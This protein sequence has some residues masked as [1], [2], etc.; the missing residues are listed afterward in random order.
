VEAELEGTGTG[1]SI[2]AIPDVPHVDPVA[3]PPDWT[4]EG[5]GPHLS[6]D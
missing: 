2:I 1:V 5:G 3:L 6:A 4:N